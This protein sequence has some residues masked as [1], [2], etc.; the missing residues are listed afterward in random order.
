MEEHL[1]RLKKLVEELEKMKGRHTELVTVYCPTGYNLN[2]VI[3]QLRQEQG[4][5]DNIKSKG[6]RKNVVGALDKLIRHLQ[7]FKRAPPNG[8][9]A[10]AGNVSES[11]GRADIQLWSFEPPQPLSVKLY[12]CDQRFELSP[13]KEMLKEREIF[14][15]IVMDKNEA[16]VAALVGKKIEVLAEIEGHVPG[17]S[18][19]GGQSAARFDRVREVLLEEYYKKL[20]DVVRKSFEGRELRGLILG[21]PGPIKDDFLNG[22]YLDTNTKK[23]VLGVRSTGYTGENGLQELLSRAE[24]LLKEASVTKERALCSQFLEELKKGSLKISYGVRQVLRHMEM[25]AAETIIVSEGLE[26][27]ELRFV[28]ECKKTRIEMAKGE[29][30]MICECGKKMA[31]SEKKNLFDILEEKAGLG[32][33]KIEVISR[34]TMEGQQL[35]ELGGIA[36]FLRYEIH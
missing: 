35:F 17:K 33:T 9:A 27:R 11:E 8:I 32:N 15:M 22:D 26:W 13:L 24:D 30:E 21:G 28:C 5:A 4:T 19:A 23:K 14:G 29:K 6:T 31:I 7:L 34:D 18:R 16:T 25:G 36:A 1:Y 20:S 12:W 10:F 3:N 2:D